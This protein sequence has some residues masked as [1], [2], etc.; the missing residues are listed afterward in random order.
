VLEH[1]VR[2][3]SVVLVHYVQLPQGA[4]QH[5]ERGPRLTSPSTLPSIVLVAVVVFFLLVGWNFSYVAAT[6]ELSGRTDPAERGKILGFA[7]LLSGLLGAG[8]ASLGG[9]A[10][11]TTGLGEL[12]VAGLALVMAPACWILR[13][14]QNQKG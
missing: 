3:R 14:T 8:F 2:P 10:L 12:A 5:S 1:R 7:D 6:A 13:T 11:A 9:L 4:G